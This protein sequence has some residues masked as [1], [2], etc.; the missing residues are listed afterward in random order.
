MVI[1]CPIDL[2]PT[3]S[4]DVIVGD[5]TLKETEINMRKDEKIRERYLYRQYD[6]LK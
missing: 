5:K 2:V 4:F 6:Y 3:A 1:S